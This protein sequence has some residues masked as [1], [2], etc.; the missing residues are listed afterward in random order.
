L[1]KEFKYDGIR[2]G[3][4]EVDFSPILRRF[5]KLDELRFGKREKYW[6][7]V[8]TDLPDD[9]KIELMG[10]LQPLLLGGHLCQLKKMGFEKIDLI[11]K[12]GVGLAGTE[13][14]IY[15]I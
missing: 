12:H 11:L 5:S 13:K 4:F 9:E 1:S 7:G 8:N 10:K 15:K 2:T 14:G 6:G 3:I